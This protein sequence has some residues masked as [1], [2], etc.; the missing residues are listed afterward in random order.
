MS[1]NHFRNRVDRYSRSGSNLIVETQMAYWRA[2]TDY[3]WSQSLYALC[4]RAFRYLRS[5]RWRKL[6][7]GASTGKIDIGTS[8]PPMSTTPTAS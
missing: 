3:H 7:L 1:D 6:P 8:S 5:A 2:Q 4:C